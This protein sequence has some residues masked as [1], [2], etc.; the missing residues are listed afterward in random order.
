MG[1]DWVELNLK[2]RENWPCPLAMSCQFPAQPLSLQ[3]CTPLVLLLQKLLSSLMAGG[4]ER[5]GG[6]LRLRRLGSPST[7]YQRRLAGGD[8]PEL[9]LRERSRH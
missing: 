5:K 7:V 9:K 3:S 4:G 2:G 8:G 6:L 1:T